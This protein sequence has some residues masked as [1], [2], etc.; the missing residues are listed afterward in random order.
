[1]IDQ[2]AL[3]CPTGVFVGMEPN[4]AFM[5]GE[6]A[7]ICIDNMKNLHVRHELRRHKRPGELV[8]FGDIDWFEGLDFMAWK[9]EQ[10]TV[11]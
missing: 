11:N 1:M 3:K 8:F 10:M 6:V 4:P 7:V 9:P 2:N 5:G